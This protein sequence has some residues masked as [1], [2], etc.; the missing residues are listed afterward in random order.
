MIDTQAI[1]LSL[2]LAACTLLIILPF[3]IWLAHHLV[4]A[5]KWKPW[6]EALLALP[7]VLPPQSWVITYWLA[8]A[9]KLYLVSLW[10]FPF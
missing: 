8:L 10:F 4:S 1:F 3:G 6:L 7:L 9:V 2:Q 5:G